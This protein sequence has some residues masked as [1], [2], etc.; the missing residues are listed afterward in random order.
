MSYIVFFSDVDRFLVV[1]NQGCLVGD[2]VWPP[3]GFLSISK[4]KKHHVGIDLGGCDPLPNHSL[5]G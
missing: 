4:A 3:Y 5:S 1:F 2:Q